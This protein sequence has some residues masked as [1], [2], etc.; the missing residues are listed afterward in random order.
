MYREN[1]PYTPEEIQTARSV[2]LTGYLESRGIEMER[3][4][5]Y[6]RLKE[7][8]SLVIDPLTNKWFWNSRALRG[9]NAVDFLMAYDNLKFTEAVAALLGTPRAAFP[10]PRTGRSPPK[11]PAESFRAPRRAPDMHRLYAYLTKTRGIA[12]E[13]VSHFVR[14]KTLYEDERHNC[15]FLGN[16][17]DGGPAYAFLRGTLTERPYKGEADGSDKRHIFRFEG[18]GSRLYVF[19]AAVDML[20]FITLCPERW[21]EHSYLPLGGLGDA[22]LAAFLARR[23]DVREIV[24]CLDDD[25]PGSLAAAKWRGKYGG[26]AATR[27][28]HPG[29][30]AG[31]VKDWNEKLL[32][33]RG[34]DPPAFRPSCRKGT[35]GTLRVFRGTH[36]VRVWVASP[37]AKA[38]RADSLLLAG[39][40]PQAHIGAF[41]RD[42]R[43]KRGIQITDIQ[44]EY[45]QLQEVFC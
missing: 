3:Q 35:N 41:C 23:P 4:G 43:A 13:V 25:I 24:F 37:A 45:E 38:R 17:P 9:Q 19:E 31:T 14:L 5:K 29:G 33:G 42:I 27:A 11:A 8:D 16:A 20:S 18:T 10:P 22:A 7:H 15:V 21:Q 2:S 34:G 28:M 32:C 40:D 36:D 26:V 30:H 44:Y 6:C 12:P 39:A 1:M